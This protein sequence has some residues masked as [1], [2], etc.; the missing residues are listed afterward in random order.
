LTARIPSLDGLRGL[1]AYIVVVSHV[2]N[3][4]G[5]WDK[6][7]GNGAGQIGVMIFFVLSGFLMGHLYI[8]REWSLDA[9]K[10]FC[11]SRVA[12]VFPLYL[13]LVIFRKKDY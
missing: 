9:V 12:R 1:A 4:T 13:A 8:G 11:V 7:F 2:S 3:A 5:L 6:N 10:R